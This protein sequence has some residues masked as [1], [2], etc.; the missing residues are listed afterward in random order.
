MAKFE[1]RNSTD[2]ADALTKEAM[3]L[4]LLRQ[5]CNEQKANVCIPEVI[6]V[7]EDSLSLTHI[8][9]ISPR[10]NLMR[11][12]GKELAKL[13]QHQGSF[14]GLEYDNYIG[15]NPQLNTQECYWGDFFFNHRLMQQI[16]WIKN[17]EVLRFF[18]Q[19][20]D[21]VKGSLIR[22]LNEHNNGPSLL[23]GD[24]WSGNALFDEK[25]A[26]LID[27]A[28]YYGDREVDIAMTEMFS[29]FSDAFYRAY[30][31]ISPLSEQY[32]LKRSIYNLYHFLNH[33][34]LFGGYY[35]HACTE[36]CNEIESKL[37]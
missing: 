18:Y 24:L 5:A 10:A 7:S 17:K 31:D 29:G 28:V 6:A 2:F 8:N 13:H 23:H 34:N 25:N 32:P 14:Y 21:K 27:P 20:A 22:F 12:L 1:K 37:T 36:L 26:W 30:Q 33:Y 16:S 9:A 11:V 3:G 35:L 4:E 15:L 19:W